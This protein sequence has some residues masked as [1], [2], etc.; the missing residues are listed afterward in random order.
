[1]SWLSEIAESEGGRLRFDRFMELAL[2]DPVHGYYARKIQR[3]GRSGD[4]S[5]STTLDTSL[6]R[7]VSHWLISEAR[8][9][10]LEPVTIIEPGIGTGA[11]AKVILSQTR[12]WQRLKY[13]GIDLR[14]DSSLLENA[15]SHHRRFRLV[16]SIE[17]ALA[18]ANGRAIVISNEFVD[19]FPCRRLVRLESGWADIYLVFDNEQWREELLPTEIPLQSSA[20]EARFPIGQI[21]ETHESYRVWLG[22]LSAGLVR[23][24]VLTIDYGGRPEEIY[25]R[26]PAGTVRGFFKQE[27]VEG[28]DIFRRVG[29]QDLTADVNFIDLQ[30]WGN[31]FGLTTVEYLTQREFVIRWYS[32]ALRKSGTATAFTLDEH[33]AGTAFKVLHQRKR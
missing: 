26:K 23:G 11:L 22:K 3:I 19:A 21:I 2:L 20:L 29:Q 24:S 18:E 14:Q 17:E 5:T 30:V 4:F 25:Q 1:M 7:A 33:G 13:Y 16:S 10:N 8:A 28:L 6:G 27:R 31:S 12:P 15:V 9:M 32:D